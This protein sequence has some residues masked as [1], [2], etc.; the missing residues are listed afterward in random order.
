[1]KPVWF[2]FAA[3]LA[4]F[5]VLRRRKLEPTVLAGGIIAVAAMVVYG[6]GVIH[7]PKIDK[8]LE[9]V[10]KALGSWTYLLVGAAA[11]FET[12]AFIGLIAPGETVMLVGGLI[13][14]QGQVNVITLIAIA[15][16]C[17][18]A[19]DVTSLFLG[20]RLGRTFLVKH[21]PRFHITEDRLRLVEGFFDRHGGKAILVGRFVGL[22]RAIAPFLA[23]SSGLSLRRFLPYDVIG[24]GL[25]V[26]SFILLGYIFWASF[27]KVLAIAQKGALALATLIVLVVAVV[28]AYRWLRQPE[29][30]ESVRTWLRAHEQDRVIGPLI[31]AARPVLRALRGPAMFV[32]NR[33][34]PGQLGLELT[35]MLAVLSVASFAFIGETIMVGHHTL[36]AADQS[37]LDLAENLYSVALVH[38]AKVVTV[39]GTL[40]VVGSAV[41]I[42]ALFA[43]Q[44]GDRL[45]AAALAGG[46]VLC[47]AGVHITKAAT[48][49]GRPPGA[50]VESDGS[51]FPSGH[52]TY[53]I[54]W[55]A[56]AVVLTRA[57][58]GVASRVSLV[59]VAIVTAVAVGL[60]RIYLRV[61]W[62]SDVVGGWGLGGTI[63]SLLGI[64]ALVVAFVRNNARLTTSSSP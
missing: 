5:L 40:P 29:N 2:F 12:G 13:A 30:R 64:A 62:M 1:L 43:L 57:L 6:T 23:G 49:R 44:R 36:A 53:A 25:W 20:R 31:R 8:V 47:W 18:V 38:I 55:I 28:V 7:L 52:A 51:S 22:V 9:D 56:V 27:D 63:F 14:G 39:L 50:L 21:G 32:W 61:H 24:A 3:A 34:T 16:V 26:T 48:D 15:W 58:P 41:A 17:A 4:G 37:A 45:P 10:G 54:A 60:T 33:L 59:T 42:T 46:L 35:T 11:F 19:G